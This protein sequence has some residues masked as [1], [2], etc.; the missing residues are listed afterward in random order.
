VLCRFHL[1]NLAHH[2][3]VPL[4]QWIVETAH[5]EGLQGSMVLEGL[6]GLRPDGSLLQES[7]WRVSRE[8]S[9]IVEVV[10]GPHHVE[11]LLARVE[12]SS[13]KGRSPSSVP[14]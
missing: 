10:D 14:M 9:I 7:P 6:M 13:R 12:P 3:A 1:P 11:T 2:G 5:R 8:V 4:Y